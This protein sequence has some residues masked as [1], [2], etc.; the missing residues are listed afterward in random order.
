MTPSLPFAV[1]G[2]GFRNRIGTESWR[3]LP[4]AS[5]HFRYRVSSLR[6]HVW[7]GRWVEARRRS[8]LP[9]SKAVEKK[10]QI[11]RRP[12]FAQIAGFI[13]N[14]A[15]GSVSPV[16]LG[17]CKQSLVLP[18][19]VVVDAARVELSGSSSSGVRERGSHALPTTSSASKTCVG[20]VARSKEGAELLG[21]ISERHTA[22]QSGPRSWPS[23][24]FP[25]SLA[26]DQ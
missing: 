13:K 17:V 9:P 4:L 7:N 20:V 5:V 8:C 12:T 1:G 3:V 23:R 15:S 11:L 14:D 2:A 26:K 6:R 25:D 21:A 16:K 18:K 19:A 10:T 22:G 24:A